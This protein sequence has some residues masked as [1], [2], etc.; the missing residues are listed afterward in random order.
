[1]SHGTVARRVEALEER[2]AAR[3]FDRSRDGYTLTA[4]GARI[5]PGA[6]RSGV[7]SSASHTAQ[8]VLQRSSCL[9]LEALEQVDS[10]PVAVNRDADGADAVVVEDP[11]CKEVSAQPIE[12]ARKSCGNSDKQGHEGCFC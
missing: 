7:S 5:L 12:R 1:M 9:I 10:H 2:L 11:P 3:L 8:C 6:E 4:A